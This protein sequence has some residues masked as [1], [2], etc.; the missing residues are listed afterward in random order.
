MDSNTTSLEASLASAEPPRGRR[1]RM[2]RGALSTALLVAS[3]LACSA[4]AV[5][6][7]GVRRFKWEALQ[8]SVGM[9]YDSRGVTELRFP[10]LGTVRARTHRL[11]VALAVTLDG[12]DFDRL[13]EMLKSPGSRDALER[14]V[15]RRSH[16]AL[17]SFAITQIL[18]GALG[19][20]LGTLILRPIRAR[21]MLGGAVVGSAATGLLIWAVVAKFDA[22]AFD[23]PSYTGS[24]RQARWIIGLAKNAFEQADTLSKR[25]TTV[26]SNLSVL[27]GRISSVPGLA[28]D[29]NTVNILHISDIHNN[30][31]AVE[32]VRELTR[33]LK[34]DAVIDTGDLTDFGTPLE[35]RLSAG[36]GTLDVPYLFVAG[37]HDSKATVSAVRSYRSAIVLDGQV[38]EVAGVRVLGAPDPSALREGEGDVNTSPADLKSASESLTNRFNEEER[39]PDIVA[40]HNSKQAQGLV[41]VARVI[42]CGHTHSASV[43]FKD[44]TAVCNAGTTGAAGARYLDVS[45][46]VPFTA[47][48]LSFSRTVPPRLLFVDQIRLDGALGQYSITRH[49]AQRTDVQSPIVPAGTITR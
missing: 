26:A 11:P 37:N 41:G 15:T 39:K 43:E 42:V 44:A 5:G 25:L 21:R 45:G 32:F 7:L 28:S 38:V 4:A 12:V 3:I 19:G 6:I 17:Q 2:V 35:T 29:A 27:Y 13:K 8:V 48:V 1:S 24:L 34:V 10:P 47:E 46:G 31:A 22:R 23:A 20:L 36:L 16:V 14:D 49:S 9:S 18:L 33:S 40:V 30:S